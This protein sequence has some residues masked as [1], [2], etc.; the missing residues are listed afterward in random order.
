M[1]NTI[2][3]GII[4][5]LGVLSAYLLYMFITYKSLC[6]QLTKAAKDMYC[7]KKGCTNLKYYTT[8]T[9]DDKGTITP[10]CANHLM[11]K[12]SDENTD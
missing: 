12:Y 11:E 5:A 10:F 1:H 7:E 4:V 8:P 6:V 9:N 2:Q 3:I